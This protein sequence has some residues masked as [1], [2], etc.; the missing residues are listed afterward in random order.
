M[1]SFYRS[2]EM[3]GANFF[4]RVAR[5]VRGPLQK[6]LTHHY[7]DEAMHSF[8]WTAAIDELEQRAIP[9]RDAYQDRYLDAVGVPS[10]LME[11]LAITQILEKRTIGHYN[12]HLRQ[13]T[14]PGPVNAA[15]EKIMV[16]ERWHI[17]YVREALAGME[18]R[19]GAEEIEST[20]TR[21]TAADI[22]V[23]AEATAEWA[24]RMTE[25]ADHMARQRERV[26]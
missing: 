23:Y 19:Y 18:E 21:F 10:N 8:Y 14:S 15:I 20:I 24:E 6:D 4:G 1:A 13:G 12:H 25:Y 26:N 9:M 5:T 17:Q 16:D 3:S 2:S 7:A 11:V 22:Q